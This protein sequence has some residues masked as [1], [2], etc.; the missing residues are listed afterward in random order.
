MKHS[1]LNP[2]RLRHNGIIIQDSPYHSTKNM[3]FEAYTTND[4]ELLTPL[5]SEGV[6]VY[7]DSRTPTSYELDSCPHVHSTNVNQ[8]WNPS[9]IVFLN[10]K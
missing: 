10:G 5:S 7:F 2:N 9:K 3:I 4:E 6:D 1:L 8:E